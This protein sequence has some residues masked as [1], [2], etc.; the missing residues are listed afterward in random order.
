MSNPRSYI[1]N[2]LRQNQDIK[3]TVESHIPKK[4]RSKSRKQGGPSS[5]GGIAQTHSNNVSSILNNS[6][7]Q[8]NATNLPNTLE[9]YSSG[10]DLNRY[11]L[12]IQSTNK[13][14]A[15]GGYKLP[16]NGV[17][18]NAPSGMQSGIVEI[19]QPGKFIGQNTNIS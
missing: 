17:G 19:Y 8:Y 12:S 2:R 18:G 3:D 6:I 13:T 1:Q 4:G 11:N 5:I 14:I 7:Y 16:Y 15:T 9:E 10:F